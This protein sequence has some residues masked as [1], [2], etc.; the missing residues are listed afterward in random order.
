MFASP[1]NEFLDGMNGSLFRVQPSARPSS[2]VLMSHDR[3][4]LPEKSR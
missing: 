1:A 2:E 4:Q 3:Q